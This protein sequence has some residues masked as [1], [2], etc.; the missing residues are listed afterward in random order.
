MNRLFL[1]LLT[2]TLMVGCSQ[3]MVYHSFDG[4][5]L[6]T[7]F[8]MVYQTPQ[9][10]NLE[11]PI[12]TLLKDFEKSLS[13]YDSTSLLCRS[14]SGQKVHLDK[15]F[16]RCMKLSEEVYS[17]TNGLYDPTLG[18]IIRAWGFSAGKATRSLSQ[19]QIDSMK[20]LIG[21]NKVR[22]MGDTLVKENAATTLDFNALAKG[23]MVDL[24]SK[25]IEDHK[26]ENYLVEIGGEIFARGVN[27]KGTKWRVGIDTPE[28]GNMVPG[29]KMLTTIELSSRAMATSGNYR[30]FHLDENGN[31]ISHT[32]DPRTARPAR[33][34]LLSA[35]I[36]APTCALADGYATACMVG[37]LEW[38]IAF[39]ERNSDVAGY[40]IYSD[41]NE[42]KSY[43]SSNLRL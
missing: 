39:V 31:K 15:W 29:E 1:S 36:I 40:F 14:N 17:K 41:G 32:I 24:V 7:T 19:K 38:S 28:D 25:L 26:I 8:H 27:A 2:I 35:T 10:E 21:F 42:M 3:N 13:L 6:G 23:Y 37:G 20:P 34:N 4:F 12:K 18:A 16:I 11:K 22:L 30:K 9:Q 33:S 5:A 43:E